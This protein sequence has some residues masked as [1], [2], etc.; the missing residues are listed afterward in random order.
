MTGTFDWRAEFHRLEGAYAA[1]TL[2]SYRSDV[3]SFVSWCSTQGLEALPATPAMVAA[4]LE[5]A[6]PR[7]AASTLRRRLCG[8]R[9]IHRLFGWPDPT[10]EEEVTLA[11]RRA[12][13]TKLCRP[14][15]AQGMTLEYLE[16][17]LAVQPDTIWGTRNRAMLSLGYDLLTR[18][19]ELVALRS[20]DVTWRADGT[21]RVLIRRSKA[22]PYGEGRIAFTSRRSGELLQDWLA[23][24]GPQITP[25]FCA[26]YHKQPIDRGLGV[27]A[28]K[29]LIKTSARRAGFDPE[30]AEA[31][32]GHS[33][34][35][36]AAQDLLRNGHDTAAIMRAGGWKSVAVLARYLEA[37]EHNVWA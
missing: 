16:R 13:R 12:L 22:D 9:K 35:V 27:S 10:R 36:G 23:L 11:L 25:L 31:F 30:I 1:E 8:I 37:A 29:K 6:A 24:R 3:Q 28:L 2:R 33:M 19:S 26:V 4:F 34:R 17:F 15:Q 18:R 7:L 14:R 20:A 32:S 5:D 21:L